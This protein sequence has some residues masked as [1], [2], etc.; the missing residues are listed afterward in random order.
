MSDQIV[1]KS[2]YLTNADWNEIELYFDDPNKYWK[3]DPA[4]V[5]S[6]I[7]SLRL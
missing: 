4:L 3:K 2:I 1:S 7:K 6:P 5:L